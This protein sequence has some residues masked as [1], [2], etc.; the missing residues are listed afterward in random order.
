[1]KEGQIIII[2]SVSKTTRTG[3]E[4]FCGEKGGCVQSNDQQFYTYALN[5]LQLHVQNIAS[6]Q[7]AYSWCRE[8]SGVETWCATANTL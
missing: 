7:E 3:T 1:M 4:H 2:G 6:V 8:V 5:T